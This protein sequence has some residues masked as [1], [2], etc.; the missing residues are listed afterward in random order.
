MAW[1]LSLDVTETSEPEKPKHLEVAQ[2]VTS[3]W[4]QIRHVGVQ[5]LRVC[6]T[7]VGKDDHNMNPLTWII[8]FIQPAGIRTN[9]ISKRY[10]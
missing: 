2:L 9:C 5:S 8:S 7:M 1:R 4:N 10:V 6:S 3:R